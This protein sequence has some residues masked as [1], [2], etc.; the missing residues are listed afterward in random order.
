MTEK[1]DLAALDRLLAAA[2]PG[3][4]GFYGFAGQE[5]PGEVRWSPIDNGGRCIEIGSTSNTEQL[6]AFEVGYHPGR[7]NATLVIKLRNAAPQM[8]ADLRA[9]RRVAAAAKA[10]YFNCSFG[11]NDLDERADLKRASRDELLAA[12]KEAGL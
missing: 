10:H 4:W 2:T 5:P 6:A 11:P 9:L 3:E 12:L 8:I 1:L 7:A